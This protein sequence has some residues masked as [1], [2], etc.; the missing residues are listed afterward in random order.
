MSAF[1]YIGTLPDSDKAYA[2]AY[3][4]YLMGQGSEPERK[5]EYIGI[6]I[7]LQQIVGGQ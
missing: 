1:K 4:D 5:P 7:A 6:R 3:F 2:R